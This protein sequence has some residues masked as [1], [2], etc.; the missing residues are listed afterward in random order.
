MQPDTLRDALTDGGEFALLDVRERGDYA[1]GHLFLAINLPLSHLELRLR[2]YV[3]R[4]TARVIVCDDGSGLS[5][6]A[7]RVL[8]AGGYT[9]VFIVAGGTPACASAGLELYRAHYAVTYA[10]GLYVDRHYR[11][12]AI[13]AQSLQAKIAAGESCVV[14][15]ARPIWDFHHAAI[16]GAIDVPLGELPYHIRDVAPDPHTQVIVNCGAVTRGVLGGRT[17]IEAGVENPVSVLTNGVRGWELAGNE[18]QHSANRSAGPASKTA[19]DWAHT[20]AQRVKSEYDVPFISAQTLQRWRVDDTRTLYV[21]DVRT[22]EEYEA[23]HLH[24][25]IWVL[26]GELIGLYEDHIGTWNARVCLVDDDT[27]RAIVTA[28]WLLRMGWPDVAVLEGG[29][30]GY[31][32]ATGPEVQDVPELDITDD[33]PRIDAQTLADRIDDSSILVLDVATS[34]QYAAGHVPG[35]WWTIRA[36]LPACID[37]IPE[38]DRYVVTSDDGRLALLAALDLRSLSDTP[39]AVLCGGTN[40]WREDGFAMVSGMTRALGETDDNLAELNVRAGDDQTT[41]QAARRRMVKWQEGLL[42]K[43]ERDDTFGFPPLP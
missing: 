5:E 2:R 36:R 28:S 15:D 40:A 6:R 7:A 31:E 26:G 21:I 42:D 38:T 27:S 17:L 39:V 32:L 30:H 9:N 8:E 34:S 16:P 37:K 24:D 1:R 23:G 4:R 29:V 20:S 3:P 41:A 18:S 22:R 43:L 13:T 35:A 12:P 19:I 11:P 33:I 14:L 25:A 10:F